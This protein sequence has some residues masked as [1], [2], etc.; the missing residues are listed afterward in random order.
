[1]NK[2]VESIYKIVNEIDSLLCIYRAMVEMIQTNSRPQ[3]EMDNEK[4][5]VALK[6][7][8]LASKIEN[9]QGEVIT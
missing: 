5:Y 3:K 9:L 8:E 7:R 4:K 2:P 6:L 1:M